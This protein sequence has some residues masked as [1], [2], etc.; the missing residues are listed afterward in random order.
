LK[1]KL[2]V[3]LW[4]LLDA[5][6]YGNKVAEKVYIHEKTYTGKDQLVLDRLKV[7]PRQSVAFVT[8]I[9]DNHVGYLVKMPGAP[10]PTLTDF[11][12]TDT[13]MANFLPPWKFACMT[14]RPK[15]SD[16]RGTSILRPAFDPWWTKQQLKP[17]FLQYL[18]QFASPGLV[19]IGPEDN[20]PIPMT[21]SKGNPIVDPATG[22]VQM[23]RPLDQLLNALLA[24]RNGTAVVVP[25]GGDVKAIEM[26]GDGAA[27]LNAFSRCDMEIAKTILAQTLATE[28]TD[29]QTRAASTVHQDVLGTL[30]RQAKSDVCAMIQD[31]VLKPLIAYN[32]GQDW[33]RWC[34][35]VSLGRTEDRDLAAMTNAVSQLMATGYLDPSQ[36]PE[37]D[38]RLG[39]PVRTSIEAAISQMQK[40]AGTAMNTTGTGGTSGSENKSGA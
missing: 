7:K 10:W 31:Q 2:S 1:P 34:P 30:V 32:Y 11:L 13:M 17:Q 40:K 9:Y 18:T 37:L 15:D 38:V 36:L 22:F 24:F 14:F 25:H 28:Q 19:G 3:V 39:L 21:D 6:G 8:D 4:S 29:H 23:V 16:P 12:M 27:F 33:E 5:I 20:T 26:V 35:I